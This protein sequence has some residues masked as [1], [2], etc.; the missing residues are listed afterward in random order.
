MGHAAQ[1]M[2]E[3]FKVTVLGDAQAGVTNISATIEPR[4]RVLMFFMTTPP[5]IEIQ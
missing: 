5:R 4:S 1:V 3:T 2:P